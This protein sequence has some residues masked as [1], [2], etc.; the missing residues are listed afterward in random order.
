MKPSDEQWNLWIDGALSAEEADAVEAAAREDAEMRGD[1]AIFSRLSEDLRRTFPAERT[2]PFPD[3]FNSHLQ[4]QLR[5]F[6]EGAPEGKRPAWW[7]DWFRLSWAVP[8]AA[9]AVVVL[10]LMQIG[11]FGG[12]ATGGSQIVY[13]YTPDESITAVTSFNRSANAMIVRLKG[14]EPLPEGFD[15]ILAGAEEAAVPFVVEAGDEEADEAFV[16]AGPQQIGVT[17]PAEAY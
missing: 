1:P 2:P 3:F 11:L 12:R 6:Q 17:P 16:F 5:D 13:A 4:K 15:L 14:M 8:L 9:A 10:A 7:P